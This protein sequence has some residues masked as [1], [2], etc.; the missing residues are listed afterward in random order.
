M[1]MIDLEWSGIFKKEMTWYDAILETL[2]NPVASK[3][4]QE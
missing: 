4:E 3:Q 1:N 2:H